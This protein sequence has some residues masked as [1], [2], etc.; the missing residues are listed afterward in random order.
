MCQCE[1]SWKTASN[2][3][4]EWVRASQPTRRATNSTCN[5][6]Q[7]WTNY[8][9]QKCFHTRH[10]RNVKSRFFWCQPER[11]C[12][13]RLEDFIFHLNPR[14]LN[15]VLENVM[16]AQR[17]PTQCNAAQ[18]SMAPHST[19]PHNIAAQHS[20]AQHSTAQQSISPHS[21]T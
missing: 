17:N 2:G 1:C 18:H 11:C 16:R 9:H 19:A 15:D 21:A 3:K 7:P 6:D 4:R 20:T 13:N 10:F 8:P 5:G 12:V 14:L